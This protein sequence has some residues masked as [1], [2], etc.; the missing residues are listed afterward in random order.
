[1]GAQGMNCSTHTWSSRTQQCPDCWVAMHARKQADIG[2]LEVPDY[3]VPAPMPRLVRHAD[4]W[5]H[6]HLHP[7]G[8]GLRCTVHHV[9][10]A[11]DE[12]CGLCAAEDD[13]AERATA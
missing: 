9:H 4:G 7:I 2:L 5:F 8:M 12:A 1:M 13:E 6:N 3:W 11:D 10:F